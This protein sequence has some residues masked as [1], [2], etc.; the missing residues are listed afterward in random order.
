LVTKQRSP[1]VTFAPIL[2]R[3]GSSEHAELGAAGAL[4]SNPRQAS[5]RQL[6]AAT[7]ELP[8]ASA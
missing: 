5:A 8:M 1:P 3:F 6:I 4:R 7:P 2:G